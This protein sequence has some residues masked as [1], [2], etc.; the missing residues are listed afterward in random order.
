[1]ADWDAQQY[2]QFESERT[3]PAIDLLARV[4]GSARRVVDIGCGPGNSTEL[5]VARFPGAE[6][7][8]LDSSD[9]MLA[10]ARARL[11]N[12]EFE[13]ADIASWRSV[14]PPDVIFA[15]AVMQW[16][17]GHVGVMARLV[18]DLAPGGRLAVQMPDN[19]DEPTHVLMRET[20]AGQPFAAKLIGAAAERE[21][22]GAFEDYYATLAARG[23]RLDLWRTTYAHVLESPPAIVEW[24]KGTGLRPFLAPLTAGEEADYLAAYGAAIAR[25]YPPMADGRV[26]LRFPRLFIVAVKD[27]PRRGSRG[28]K[29]SKARLDAP[30]EMI[31]EQGRR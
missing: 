8:G 30:G 6:V 19:I 5:L 17:P 12:L 21:A 20:A 15:N 7:V 16:V 24:V 25:A 23:A 28:V 31:A 22:I 4:A 3:R 26:I 2:L 1:M 29:A 11:P 18:D 10:M 27:A 14:T 13:R 9:D